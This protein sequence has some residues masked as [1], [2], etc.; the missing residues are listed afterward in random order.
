MGSFRYLF[1]GTQARPA[2]ATSIK[3]VGSPTIP[4]TSST[5]AQL[6]ITDLSRFGQ[7]DRT[8]ITT[9]R[10]QPISLFPKQLGISRQRWEDAKDCMQA[11]R[12]QI[13]F[14]QAS[15]FLNI[16]KRDVSGPLDGTVAHNVLKPTDVFAEYCLPHSRKPHPDVSIVY[17]KQTPAPG[18][19][20]RL[21]TI[22][23]A[24]QILQLSQID[25][26]LRLQISAVHGDYPS[27]HR[28]K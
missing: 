8:A 22:L 24:F 26:L 10:T 28:G 14:F 5:H 27:I 20:H 3:S 15:L 13:Q 19:Q 7:S 23:H 12:F 2:T 6:T 4:R 18:W 16:E 11:V 25:D 9:H 21:T 1:P 17:R